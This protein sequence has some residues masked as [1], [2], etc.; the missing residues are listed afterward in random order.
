MTLHSLD[1]IV[2]AY[3]VQR[4]HYPRTFTGLKEGEETSYEKSRQCLVVIT[5]CLFVFSLMEVVG[6]FIYLTYVRTSY[7]LLFLEIC[8]QFHP[9]IKIIQQNEDSEE[10]VPELE[11]EESVP[12]NEGDEL[13]L[14]SLVLVNAIPLHIP[15]S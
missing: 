12:E 1:T 14:K 7:R 4:S 2:L 8:I 11:G 13:N 15:F 3:Q 9:W 10:I 6:Y 5:S